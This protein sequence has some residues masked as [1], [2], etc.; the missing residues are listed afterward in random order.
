MTYYINNN[1]FIFTSSQGLLMKKL[2]PFL[3]GLSL[4]GFSLS[5]HAEDLLQVYQQAKESN[6]TLRSSAAQRDSAYEKINESRSSL[7]PQLGLSADY[8]LNKSFRGA[9]DGTRTDSKSG[10]VSLTQSLFNMT[11]WRN[12]DVTKKL[13]SVQDIVYRA[14]EQT[15]IL[16]TATAYFGVLRAL[17][18]YS[19]T[20]A[21]KSAIGRQLE[22]T[23]QRFNVGLVAITDVHDAQAQYDQTLADEVIKRND[24][25]NALEELR[26]VTGLIYPTLNTVNTQKFRTQ[27]APAVDA[28]LNEAE[29][30]NLTLLSARLS[31]ELA[32]QQIKVSQ[33]GH[34]PTLDLT[35]SSGIGNTDSRY[36]GFTSK[37]Q[38][39]SNQ[40]GVTFKLPLYSGGRTSSQVKQA[41]YDFVRYSEDLESTHRS[42]V[43]TVRSSHNNILAAIS[44][45]KAYKQL[46]ISA[47]SSL[48]ATEAGY[49]AG[50]R[51][52]VDVLNSTQTLYDA[53]ARLSNAR[54]DYLINVLALKSAQGT[55]NESDLVALNSEL[56]QAISTT[57]AY[58]R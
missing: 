2:L 23:R 26:L 43:K 28:L 6:P 41:K 7:L 11:N 52:I 18:D 35:A 5:S 30:N 29:N 24:I 55:L 32:R 51:T 58:K 9:K 34:L 22:Q 57:P 40:V 25:E 19:F 17:D 14:Q 38:S 3:I 36:D 47:D 33:S 49:S 37:S 56:G 44:T 16:D 8:S 50:T 20:Q 21:K 27:N 45:I 46:V 54:Y 4:S 31:Q 39:G 42:V 13:A 53:K 1:E 12:L 15:L 48:K 10:S